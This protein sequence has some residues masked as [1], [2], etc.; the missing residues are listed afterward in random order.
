M[1]T[2]GEVSKMFTNHILE[3]KN[4]VNSIHSFR[5]EDRLSFAVAAS[6]NIYNGSISISY[7]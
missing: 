2:I 3:E 6:K 5:E 4:L 1:Y 7:K